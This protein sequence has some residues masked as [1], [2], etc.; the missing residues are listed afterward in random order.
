M[1]KQNDAIYAGSRWLSNVDGK[2]VYVVMEVKGFGRFD[3]KK[4]GRAVFGSTTAR[5]LR[6]NFTRLDG[7][8][9]DADCMREVAA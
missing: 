4:E 7:R 2:T 1:A 5:D 9:A 6:A 8:S 3:V